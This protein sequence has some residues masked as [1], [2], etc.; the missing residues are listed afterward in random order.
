MKTRILKYKKWVG[1][2]LV[3]AALAFAFALSVSN[4]RPGDLLFFIKQYTDRQTDSMPF[5]A[6]LE[7]RLASSASLAAEGKCTQFAVAE[8]ELLSA[9]SK[10]FGAIAEVTEPVLRTNLS[11]RAAMIILATDD[12]KGCDSSLSIEEIGILGVIIAA[13]DFVNQDL[14]AYLIEKV[15]EIEYKAKELS[16]KIVVADSS[17]LTQEQ[18]DSVSEALLAI[19]D[20][21]PS[22]R[23]KIELNEAGIA[24]V[25]SLINL[26]LL[27]QIQEDSNEMDLTWRGVLSSLC[28]HLDRKGNCQQAEIEGLWNSINSL[29]ASHAQRLEAE[30]QLVMDYLATIYPKL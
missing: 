18:L 12:Y 2:L 7:N 5:L 9:L 14:R 15:S 22:L 17:L 19:K 1:M 10:S 20:A 16:E 21:T 27:M 29:N 4:S 23:T 26:E 3:L 11:T 13:N 25:V 8:R 30:G 24:E 28:T 6:T